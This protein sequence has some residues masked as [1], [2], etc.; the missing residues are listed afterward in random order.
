VTALLDLRSHFSRFLGAV[1]GRLH[2]AAHSHHLWPDVTREAQLAVWDDAAR[3]ADDKWEHVLG[4]VLDRLRGRIARQL[5]LPDPAT[6]VFAPNTH[7]FLKRLLSCFPADRPVRVLSSDG[8]FHTFE[9]QM[10]RLAEDGLV[11][12]ERVPVEPF[13]TF[14]ARFFEAARRPRDLVFVSQVFFNSGFALDDLSALAAGVGEAMLVVD[15]YHGFLARPTDLAAVAD[16]AFYLA[17]GYKYAMAGEGACFMHC[18]PGWGARPRDTGWYAAFGALSAPRPGA[19]G[20]AADGWRFMG[21]TFDPSGLYRLDATLGW[22]EAQG[23]HAA[24][25]HG[26]AM[27]LARRFL[28]GLPVAGFARDQLVADPDIAETGN[29]LTFRRADAAAVNQRMHAADIVADVRGDRL[30]IGFGLYQTAD[31]IDRLLDRLAGLSRD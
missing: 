30:R 21:A 2:F 9:R 27:A 3:L 31:D 16:R 13:A 23:L 24:A 20:Y 14:P 26:H 29:F 15:G 25:I 8:E 6:L 17:G 18:P 7:E 28:G 4:P 12:L 11:E 19:V 1:P 10:A 22:L 5:A